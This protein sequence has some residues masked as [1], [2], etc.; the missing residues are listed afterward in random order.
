MRRIEY[1][2]KPGE[3]LASFNA[4]SRDMAAAA[5]G[6]MNAVGEIALRGGRA[7]IGAGG[8][9]SRWRNAYRLKVFPSRSKPSINAAAYL[10]H[11]ISYS[12]V[13][14]DG[15]NITGKPLL[16]IPLSGTP[17]KIGRQRLTAGNYQQLTGNRLVSIKRPGK[18]P[19]LGGPAALSKG[20]R[21]KK[22]RP[23]DL[24][25]PGLKSPVKFVIG[26]IVPL[27]VGISAVSLR[28]RFDT[29]PAA[30]AAAEQIETLYFQQLS[31]TLLRE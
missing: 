2:Y 27:F 22:L 3:A 8:F 4:S 19:L 31:K 30:E 9:S 14:Q 24:T 18:P 16:Y 26:K 11:R 1:S 10:F 7:A 20:S 12:K 13:F 15:A 21:R 23:S 6:A 25:A 29:T 28:K 5:T 17:K